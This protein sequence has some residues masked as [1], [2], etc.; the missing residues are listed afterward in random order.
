ME[1][2]N[3]KVNYNCTVIR[4][5]AYFSSAAIAVIREWNILPKS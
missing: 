2:E 5:A 3:D 1:E 4:L